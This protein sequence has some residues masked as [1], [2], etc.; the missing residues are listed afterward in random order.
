[1]ILLWSWGVWRPLMELLSSRAQWHKWNPGIR[2][3][4]QEVSSY[5]KHMFFS[6]TSE[7]C[8]QRWKSEYGY[9]LLTPSNEKL[10]TG[11]LFQENK[12]TNKQR[13]TTN[14][15]KKCLYNPYLQL[16]TAKEDRMWPPFYFHS[17]D[18]TECI[19]LLKSNFHL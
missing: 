5:W 4:N 14:K 17:S 19:H 9:F 1:M 3:Q 2:N 16:K 7:I 10:D 11:I 18:L 13:K 8:D 6:T 15:Q 12:Q